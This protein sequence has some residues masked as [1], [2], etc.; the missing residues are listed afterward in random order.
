MD[1]KKIDE[2]KY[3]FC[4]SICGLNDIILDKNIFNNITTIKE[5]GANLSGGQRQRISIARALYANRKILI[6]DE[7]T[8]S[9]DESSEIKIINQILIYIMRKLSFM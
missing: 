1:K 5:N 4:L 6:F 3:F 8:N 7:A 2:N 9:L